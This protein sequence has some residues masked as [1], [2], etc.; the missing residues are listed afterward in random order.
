[1]TGTPEGLSR[2]RLLTGLAAT[3]AL[4]LPAPAIARKAGDFRSLRLIST[5]TDE[6]LNTVYWIDGAYVPE[7]LDAISFLLRDWREEAVKPIAPQTID[8]LAEMQR[9]I[10]ASEPLKV[11]SG[12]R[13]PRTNAMLRRNSRGV[14]RKSFHVKAMAVDVTME[15]RSTRQ[16]ARAALSLDAGGVGLYSR[17]EFVHV[18]SGPIRSWGR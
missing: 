12:Y 14:A 4:A 1:M 13:T 8:I 15:T 3:A 11:I 6:W 7:A 9:R 5:H 10:D 17:S 16:L 2:R 18:D